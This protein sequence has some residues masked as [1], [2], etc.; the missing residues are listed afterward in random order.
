MAVDL[1]DFEAHIGPVDAANWRRRKSSH[2]IGRE[3]VT[4]WGERWYGIS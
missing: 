1:A 2:R 4:E 3:E